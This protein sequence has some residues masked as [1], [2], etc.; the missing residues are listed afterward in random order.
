MTFTRSLRI[1][2][3][4]KGKVAPETVAQDSE[5]VKTTAADKVQRTETWRL[6]YLAFVLFLLES[7]YL[8][9]LLSN[10][11]WFELLGTLTG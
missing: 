11:R 9:A 7:L 5:A 1:A 8:I 10:H 3:E 4:E 2:Q 6:E